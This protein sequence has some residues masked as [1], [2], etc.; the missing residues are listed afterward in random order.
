MM[1][2]SPNHCSRAVTSAPR[3]MSRDTVSTLPVRA[4]V[5]IT[6]SPAAVRALGSAPASSS[7]SS[8]FTLPLVAA[9]VIGAIP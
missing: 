5:M 9:S 7:A 2:V 3:A 6:G 8:T 1:A 4:A